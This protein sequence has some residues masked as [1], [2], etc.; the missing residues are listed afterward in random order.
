MKHAGSSAL[1]DLEP[2]LAQ[3]RGLAGM[4]E[5]K[6]GVF[7]RGS[8][9]FL[10]FHEDPKGLFADLRAPG[11]S[12]FERFDVTAPDGRQRLLAAAAARLKASPTKA[13][14]GR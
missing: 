9:A 8:Q 10:H 4:V 14:P 1:D 11:G 3:L 6:R 2:L 12:D 5:K 13:P 7:Y